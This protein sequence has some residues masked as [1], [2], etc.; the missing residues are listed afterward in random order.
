MLDSSDSDDD[1]KAEKSLINNQNKVELI[2]RRI[3]AVLSGI[4]DSD[5]DSKKKF[6]ASVSSS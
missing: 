1:D 4:S 6:S 2:N 5:D 3:R